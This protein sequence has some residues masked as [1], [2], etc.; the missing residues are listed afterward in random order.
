MAKLFNEGMDCQAE[1]AMVKTFG[2]EMATKATLTLSNPRWIWLYGRFKVNDIFARV[3]ARNWRRNNEIQR[4]LL[5]DTWA[6]EHLWE[7]LCQWKMMITLDWR[8]H[9]IKMTL[10]RLFE[11]KA[12]EKYRDGLMRIY[13]LALLEACAAGACLALKDEDYITSTHRGHGHSSQR[14]QILKK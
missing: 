1:A 2:T 7:L 5:P 4:L 6:V 12:A 9:Y 13:T 14:V 11:I 3:N 8:G 10:I